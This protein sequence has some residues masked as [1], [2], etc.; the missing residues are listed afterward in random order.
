MVP[1]DYSEQ[2]AIAAEEPPYCDDPVHSRLSPRY[3]AIPFLFSTA[4]SFSGLNTGTG[5][6]VFQ[7]T[8]PANGFLTTANAGVAPNKNFSPNYWQIQPREARYGG[9]VQPNLDVTQN[10]QMYRQLLIQRNEESAQ[11]PNQGF[12]AADVDQG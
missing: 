6:T 1:F 5:Y 4:G 3:P 10:L 2:C 9:M 12:S 8:R 11:T 7:G